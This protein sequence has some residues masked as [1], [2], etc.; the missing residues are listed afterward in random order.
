M[1]QVG[2]LDERLYNWHTMHYPRYL[3]LAAALYGYDIAVTA[4]CATQAEEAETRRWC[5]EYGAAY[6]ETP[7]ELIAR[8]DGI[9]VMAADECGGHEALAKPALMSGK[10]VF[11]DKTFAPDYASASRMFALAGAHNTPVFS[12]SSQRFCM[13]LL[14]WKQRHGAPYRLVSQGPGDLRNYSIHQ[15]E[16]IEHLM[17]IGA[18]RCIA[19][20]GEDARH[21]LYEYGNGR[22]A[23]MTQ[24]M[25]AIP[26]RLTVYE[27][28]NVSGEDIAVTDHY[29]T[30]MLSL[31]RF[32]CGGVLPVSPE[33]TLEIMAMQE[34]GKRA[35]GQY[36]T[37]ISLDAV[38]N[39]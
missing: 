17:G 37:W 10:P 36:G 18:N 13:E 33:D 34:A 11:C 7:E 20:G 2:I 27:Q 8:C 35:C 14:S 19:F 21:I 15:Y 9:M 30:L 4:A 23:Q 29:M 22:T 39:G 28:E 26:F 32:F 6:C 1:V 24:M 12:C 3:K 25:P 16:M 31:C 38:R 5:G